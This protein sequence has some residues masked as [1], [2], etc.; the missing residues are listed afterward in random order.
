MTAWNYFSGLQKW[1][2]VGI[3][4]MHAGV[5]LWHKLS[6]LENHFLLSYMQFLCPLVFL[7]S[8]VSYILPK[9]IAT[10]AHLSAMYPPDQRCLGPLSSILVIKFS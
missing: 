4:N 6:G 10:Q 1:L 5:I 8:S 3:I 9:L 7:F 2:C